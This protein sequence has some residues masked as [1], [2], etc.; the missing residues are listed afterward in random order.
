VT[1]HV[2]VALVSAIRY[3]ERFGKEWQIWS[4]VGVSPRGT[5]AL[6]RAARAH[7]WL[8]G[9]EYVTPH[10]ACAV[11]HDCLRH[12][13]SLSYEATTNSL[14]A[15]DVINEVVKQVAVV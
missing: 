15:D 1:K 14:S 4:R 10:N 3:P 6:D 7:A 9:G 12:R 8:R 11:V 5:L 2:R 13:L